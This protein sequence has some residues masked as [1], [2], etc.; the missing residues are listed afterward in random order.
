MA[1]E[2]PAVLSTRIKEL[3]EQP[4]ESS[5]QYE[6]YEQYIETLWKQVRDLVEHDNAHI[7]AQS[8][9]IKL[10]ASQESLANAHCVLRVKQTK[11]ER[12]VHDNHQLNLHLH[13][14]LLLS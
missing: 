11:V 3:E 7:R 10:E 1:D 14:E 12:L 13:K 4:V 8:N 5:E 2:N 6:Q 9:L